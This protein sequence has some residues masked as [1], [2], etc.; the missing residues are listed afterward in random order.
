MIDIKYENGEIKIT[1]G[2]LS[3]IYNDNQ[4]PLSFNMI[5][6]V[7]KE[8]LWSTKLTDNMWA[9]YQNNEMVD[10][11]VNDKIGNTILSYN[12]NVISHGSVFYKSLY[13]YCLNLLKTGKV[14]QG[15]V[16]GTHDGEFGEW[17]PTVI[18]QLSVAT[19]VEGG[20]PQFTKLRENYKGYL[21]VTT[22]MGLVTTDGEDVT[23]FEGGRGYTNSVVENVIRKWETEEI[24]SSVRKSITIN[25]IIEENLNGHI[26]WLHLDV[27]GLDA[28]LIMSMD[29]RY[30]PNF[31]IFEYANLEEQEIEEIN[32]WLRLRNFK[33]YSDR[34]I[35]MA[36]R[37]V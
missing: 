7:S 11:I 34:G 12:W 2:N 3:M 22:L 8:P 9:T 17:V 1:T 4:L 20:I 24:K 36:T 13:W 30:I 26:D 5:K 33:L 35:T 10:V 32:I 29:E 15:L 23:F 19:L 18:N 16:I 6:S 37:V 14:P 31:I 28:K 27:E 21:N 25:N